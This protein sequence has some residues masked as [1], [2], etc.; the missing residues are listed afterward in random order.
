MNEN[1]I[2]K[3]LKIGICKNV[4]YGSFHLWQLGLSTSN[5]KDECNL[6]DGDIR[7]LDQ[8]KPNVELIDENAWPVMHCAVGLITIFH[9]FTD[10]T[11][12]GDSIDLLT[13]VLA[14]KLDKMAQDLSLLLS[15]KFKGLPTAF[16]NPV[17]QV[18]SR[19]NISLLKLEN[20]YRVRVVEWFNKIEKEFDEKAKNNKYCNIHLT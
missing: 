10:L 8:F 18:L 2:Q 1:N 9:G 12:A 20:F 17:H 19:H 3:F 4:I 7:I 15:R 11:K 14:A 16:K 13:S 5:C 6:F